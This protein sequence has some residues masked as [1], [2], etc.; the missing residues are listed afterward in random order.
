MIETRSLLIG[1]IGG[2]GELPT[3]GSKD[4]NELLDR[5]HKR[6]KKVL[7]GKSDYNNEEDDENRCDQVSRSKSTTSVGGGVKA[8]TTTKSSSSSRKKK[9]K[10]SHQLPATVSDFDGIESS[11]GG[12]ARKEN[13]IEMV[14]DMASFKW[15]DISQEQQHSSFKHDTIELNS[16]TQRA[17]K[18]IKF[19]GK[20]I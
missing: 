17:A 9:S 1:D 3:S 6:N 11:G 13:L 8:K 10:S 16:S 14:R 19:E 20:I 18:Q 7:R 5:Q 2:G 4:K 12:G 15:P